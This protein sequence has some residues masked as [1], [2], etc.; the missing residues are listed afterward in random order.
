MSDDS[1]KHVPARLPAWSLQDAKRQ[2]GDVV[3]A[4]AGRPQLLTRR[5]VPT[6]VVISYR[7]YARVAA[8]IE[9]PRLSFEAFLLTMPK[10]D[11][12]TDI[13]FERIPLVPRDVDF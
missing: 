7:D 12:E 5:G 13:D 1:T 3:A 11:A 9:Q 4:A 10:A 2:L 6:A 8:M